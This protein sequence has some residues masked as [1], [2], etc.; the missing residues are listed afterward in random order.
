MAGGQGIAAIAERGAGGIKDAA[1]AVADHAAGTT[2]GPAAD[3]QKGG[4]TVDLLRAPLPR[5]PA[6]ACPVLALLAAA[7]LSPI[8]ILPDVLAGG[9]RLPAPQHGQQPTQRPASQ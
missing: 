5:L 7:V 6:A 1:A 4:A 8:A 2:G 9:G 3:R